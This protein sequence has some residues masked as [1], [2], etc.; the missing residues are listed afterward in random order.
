MAV[1]ILNCDQDLFRGQRKSEDEGY[2][3][4]AQFILS[5]VRKGSL[6]M[7]KKGLCQDV[8]DIN[9]IRK[10]KLRT[11]RSALISLCKGNNNSLPIVR[12]W[13]RRSKMS[14]SP[15]VRVLQ[16]NVLSQSLGSSIDKFVNCSSQTLDWNLRKWKLIEEIIKHDPDIICLQEVDHFRMLETAL[17]SIGYRGHFVPKPDSP[18]LYVDNNNGPDGCAVFYKDHMFQKQ[19]LHTRTLSVWGVD[20]NQ[21]AVAMMLTHKQSGQTMTVVTTHL[22]ARS[23]DINMMMR[24]EQGRDLVTWVDNV[25]D[26]TPVILT[27]DLNAKP[28]EPVVEMITSNDVIPLTSSYNLYT[29]S[30]TTC[31]VRQGGKE[32]KMLDYILTSPELETVATLCLPS[33]DQLGPSL[34]PSLQFPSDHL[35][36]VADIQL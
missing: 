4:N 10:L 29:T 26:N 16:W 1:E 31:K 27:G 35:T 33:E 11:S 30:M 32:A 5:I 14:S 18:C 23:G 34:L 19:S 17:S 28:D 15:T 24:A 22:K 20:S 12:S 7:V 2:V 25:R 13:R 6:Q 36:L 3:P 8:Q 9:M 21:V